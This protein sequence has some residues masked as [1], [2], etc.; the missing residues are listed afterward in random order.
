MVRQPAIEVH[1]LP[2]GK[3]PEGV[4]E[5]AVPGVAPAIANALFAASGKRLRSLPLGER[6]EI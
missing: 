5:T 2:Q 4:G 6:I 1:L 3:R